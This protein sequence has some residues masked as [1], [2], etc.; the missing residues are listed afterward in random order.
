MTKPI[1]DFL[2]DKG[3]VRVIEHDAPS[4][5]SD[6]VHQ[7][8]SLFREDLE[9]WAQQLTLRRQQQKSNGEGS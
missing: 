7:I 2:K 6:N 9:R 4:G 5:Y 1:P 8:T 3:I